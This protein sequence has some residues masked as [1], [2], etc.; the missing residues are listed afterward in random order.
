MDSSF[1]WWGLAFIVRQRRLDRERT[2]ERAALWTPEQHNTYQ[3]EL[4]RQEFFAARRRR[5]VL[6][7]FGRRYLRWYFWTAVVFFLLDALS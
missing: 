7:R 5:E 1:G 6:G 2:A 4:Q 3:A